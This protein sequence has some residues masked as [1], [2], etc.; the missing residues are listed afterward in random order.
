MAFKETKP[1]VQD[2][3]PFKGFYGENY[4]VNCRNN[5]TLLQGYKTI[6]G[7]ECPEFQII[8]NS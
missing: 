4:N 3:R 7:K 2:L 8:Y 1:Q 6:H 5:T